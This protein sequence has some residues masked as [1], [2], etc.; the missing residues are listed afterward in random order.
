MIP[1]Y[2]RL[3]M[4]A[5]ARLQALKAA[6]VTD[7]RKARTYGFKSWESAY[8][9]L[10]Q[11]FNGTDA[12]RIPIWYRHDG[13]YFRNETDAHEVDGARLDGTGWFTDPEMQDG[14]CIG[15]V[16]NLTHG[17]YIAGYRLAETGERVYFPDTHASAIDA[18][19]MADEHARVYAGREAE[20]QQGWHEARKV[21]DE[22]ETALQRLREVLILRHEA[23]M[24]YA[25]DEVSD[26]VQTTRDGRARL[27]GELLEW[28]DA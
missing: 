17:R 18:A 21:E 26:L 28:R 1:R 16:G 4:G 13:E 8:C 3:D 11:G 6:N 5:R 20:Y 9:A 22:I 2:L 7:W 25:R 24:R 27:A 12:N 19:R 10:D 14:L 15:I 23:C